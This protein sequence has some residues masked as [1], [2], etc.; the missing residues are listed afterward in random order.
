MSLSNSLWNLD[1]VVTIDLISVPSMD[2]I[3]WDEPHRSRWPFN[4]GLVTIHVIQVRF[5]VLQS[6]YRDVMTWLIDIA[7]SPDKTRFDQVPMESGR[8]GQ[9]KSIE[10]AYNVIR[11]LRAP[12]GALRLVMSCTEDRLQY[13]RIL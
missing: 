13:Q 6:A 12:T 7:I 9:D 8:I 2:S 4:Q 1:G 10:L 5:G 3:E 11:T